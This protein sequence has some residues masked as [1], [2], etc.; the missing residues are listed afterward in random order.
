MY[1]EN[2]SQE[3]N[4]KSI[5]G[6]SALNSRGINY[7]GSGYIL[8]VDSV[9]NLYMLRAGLLLFIRMYYS[10]YTAIGICHAFMLTGCWQSKQC[11]LFV[12]IVRIYQ[13]A[14]STEH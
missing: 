2:Y 13:D 4:S 14:R 6:F 5:F 9:I 7:F 1:H 11:I 10:V 12:L 3:S 8:Y